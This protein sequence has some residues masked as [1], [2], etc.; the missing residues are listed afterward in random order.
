MAPTRRLYSI[1][2]L[3]ALAVFGT[4]F[5]IAYSGLSIAQAST[6]LNPFV[7]SN[8]DVVEAVHDDN[9]GDAV[10]SSLA[11]A[12]WPSQASSPEYTHPDDK[13]VLEGGSDAPD[14]EPTQPE[15]KQ[16]ELARPEQLNIALIE[17]G[18][19]HDEVTAAFVHAFA[20]QPNSTFAM[21]LTRPR[22]GIADII[23]NFNLTSHT[24][25]IWNTTENF[26][27]AM[28]KA[29]PPHILISTTC[30]L[31]LIFYEPVFIALLAQSQT[32]LFCVVHHADR[33]GPGRGAG[34]ADKLRP[35]IEKRR[36]TFLT[37]S[38]H[39]AAHLQTASIDLWTFSA[40]NVS[41]HA[42]PPVFPVALPASTQFDLHA[43][44]QLAMQGDYS[45]DRRN[46]TSVFELLASVTRK[47][48]T[49]TEGQGTVSLHL[50]GHGEEPAVPDAIRARVS[51]D[52][53]LLYHDF[54]TILSHQFAVLPAFAS[55]TYYDRKASSSIPA[56]LIAGAPV[57]ASQRL[58]D[59]YTY[60]PR[61][62]V[63][64]SR[65]GESEMQVIERVVGEGQ[66]EEFERKREAARRACGVLTEANVGLA[67]EWVEEALAKMRLAVRG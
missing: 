65:E 35:W 9:K 50:I 24:R 28:T 43:G 11:P 45:S 26:A 42:F 51:F 58:L 53:N 34:I 55:E 19:S 52:E 8:G 18:G 29:T 40:H 6:R 14:H 30:E 21:Y 33:W 22:Y 4:Y 38:A 60:L 48:E 27:D 54:Y 57:V 62:A 49:A 5:Y 7:T 44:I 61:E 16:S 17:S 15:H 10:V 2:L 1:I 64:L 41:I 20:S 63:W 36:V 37:L 31:D 56:A 23:N 25:P 59:A 32:F 67:G 39:T 13:S 12:L 46:Y 47:I 66:G 3:S